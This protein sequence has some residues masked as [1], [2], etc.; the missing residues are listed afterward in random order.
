MT[1]YA[2][3]GGLV[4]TILLLASAGWT[5][6]GERPFR[7][8]PWNGFKAAITLTYD[9]GD[10]IHLDLA[11]PEMNERK[12]RGT[13]FLVEKWVRRE[14]EWRNAAEDGH[15]IGNHSMTH[16]H[17]TGL[18][19]DQERA[20]VA[21]ARKGLERIAGR[22]VLSFAYPFTEVTDGLRQQLATNA[23]AARGG[24]GG[25]YMT[26]DPEPDWLNIPS[27]ATLTSHPLDQY[28]RWVEEVLTRGAWT[29]LMIHAIE[30]S[31]MWQP[32]PKATFLGLLDHLAGKRKDLWIAPFLEVASYWKAQKVLERAPA[33]RE[34]ASIVLR[35]SRP[36]PFPR[37]VVLKVRLD[38]KGVRALQGGKP[39]RDL[40]G[41]LQ[42]VAF[43][44]GELTLV[45]SDWEPGDDIPPPPSDI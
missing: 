34:G 22:P 10:P 4:G 15:E 42:A 17:A 39:L 9:D 32:V 12:M 20:E 35:W 41:G 38:G 36:E 19:P 30:G 3:I 2:S 8:L 11:I 31:D 14:A 28:R 21:D 27:Q 44:A 40:P 33:A 37:G 23:V 13:F 29:V 16:P 43:D 24:Y 26:P 6:A 25:Y 18:K 7:V 5:L 1:R 45:G